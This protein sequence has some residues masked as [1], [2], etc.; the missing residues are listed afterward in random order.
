MEKCL[1]GEILKLTQVHIRRAG[2]L[3]QVLIDTDEEDLSDVKSGM[4]AKIILKTAT[5]K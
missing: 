3:I 5:E 2:N 4:Y 1:E